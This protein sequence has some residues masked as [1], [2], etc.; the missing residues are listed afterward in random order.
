MISYG[1]HYPQNLKLN[2]NVHS[3]ILIWHR[4]ICI[5]WVIQSDVWLS[6]ELYVLSFVHICFADSDI[7]LIIV[8]R[9]LGPQQP[10]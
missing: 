8:E 2:N 4:M 1:T 3:D 10:I 6:K 7:I 5:I 9:G